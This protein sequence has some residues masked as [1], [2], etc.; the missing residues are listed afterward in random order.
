MP[1]YRRAINKDIRDFIRYFLPKGAPLSTV[2]ASKV[3]RHL[4]LAFKGKTTEEIYDIL[5]EQLLRA[6]Q[7]YD[8][9]Y[10]EKVK[11]VA[12]VINAHSQTGAIRSR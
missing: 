2:T 6:I 3:V 11:L 9:A 4:H 7:K 12:E 10:T 8:P 1:L 5:M